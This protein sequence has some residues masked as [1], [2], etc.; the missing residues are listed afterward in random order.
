MCLLPLSCSSSAVILNDDYCYIKKKSFILSFSVAIFSAAQA[1]LRLSGQSRGVI[2]HAEASLP[3][4]L[5]E[6]FIS[7]R[8]LQRD[9]SRSYAVRDFPLF[10]RVV[11]AKFRD[12][13][14]SEGSDERKTAVFCKKQ[15][16]GTQKLQVFD[17]NRR[18]ELRTC[19]FLMKTA[20]RNSETAGF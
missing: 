17:E 5:R 14:P 18:R 1:S 16:S 20:V 19:S 8:L 3:S 7:R 10:R 11:N 2:Y 13:C 9:K 4:T 15:P 6:I 12:F